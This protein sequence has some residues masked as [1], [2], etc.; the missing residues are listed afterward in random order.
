MS[1]LQNINFHPKL[2][3]YLVQ[4]AIFKQ[5][6]LI[7]VDVG[8]RGGKESHWNLLGDQVK[9]LGFD[10]DEKEC[11]RL[12]K[13]NQDSNARYF[14]YALSQKQGKRKFY[15]MENTASSSFFKPNKKFWQRFPDEK[16]LT[17]KKEIKVNTI[18]LNTFSKKENVNYIDFIKLDVEGAEL[19]A[20]KGA[21]GILKENVLGVA[22][23]ISFQQTLIGQPVFSDID[24]FL[25]STGFKLF[26]LGQI[27]LARKTVSV[28]PGPSETGQ[29]IAGHALYL[30]DGVEELIK[31]T[32]RWGLKKIM[33]LASIME[34]YGLVDCA[35]ELIISA[36][37]RSILEEIESKHFIELLKANI[38]PSVNFAGTGLNNL[39]K[40]VRRIS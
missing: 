35:I 3:R 22:L 5:E 36:K 12:N 34:I 38:N 2:T 24:E 13:L 15:I 19:E 27:R 4:K 29:I 26:D 28:K 10:A 18:D 9:I 31:S 16:N 17:V 14:P 20:L 30:R 37:K 40:M 6:P 25:R 32:N 7:I 21:V 11:R 8:A 1:S 23:E 39:F 33:K